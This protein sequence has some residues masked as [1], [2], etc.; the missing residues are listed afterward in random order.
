MTSGNVSDE[1]IAFDDAEAL[2]RLA[3]DRRP[4]P[5]PRPPDRDAHRRLGARR[6][7]AAGAA[8]L[9]R[10]GAG[11]HRAAGRAER[12]LL[13]C[14]AELKSTF[15]LAKGGRAWVGHH[16]GDLRTGRR[17]ARSARGSR[18]SSGCSRSPPSVVAHDLHPDYLSTAYALER[19]GRR[20]RRA[21]STTTRTL[22]PAW[23]STARPARRSARS[24]T[25]RA[26]GTRRHDLGRRAAGRRR[27]TA[28]SAPAT[29]G[30]SA[31]PAATPPCASRGGWHAR[32]CARSATTTRRSR[33]HSPST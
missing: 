33:P 8:P 14:G 9:A 3:L 29:S 31:C 16:I 1:P 25:A 5:R 17:C 26:T 12:P 18:T 11:E 20:A 2:E 32:G 28:T 23:Q 15:C 27:S 30:P 21:C 13:A 4:L 24:T 7:A 22:P 19:E 6:A 10:T